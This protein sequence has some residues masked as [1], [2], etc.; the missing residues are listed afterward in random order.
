MRILKIV[1]TAD[2]HLGSCFTSTPEI[3]AQRKAEQLDT[4]RSIVEMCRENSSDALLIAG[5]LFDS[6]RVEPQLVAEVQDIL[7]SCDAKVFISPGNHDP[8]APDSCYMDEGWPE[9]VHIFKGGLERVDLEGK[10]TSIWGLGF[11]HSIEVDSLLTD[12]KPDD[13]YINILLMH[14]ELVPDEASE[15]RYN[16]VTKEKLLSLGMDYC[17]LGHIHKAQAEKVGEFMYCNCGCPEGRGFDELGDKG[18]YSGHVGKGFVHMEFVST[19]NRKYVSERV[20]VSG[21]SVVS[22]FCDKIIGAISKSQGDDYRNN[23]YSLTLIGALPK[24]IMPDITAISKKLMETVH[25]VRLTDMT[26]TELDINALMKDNSLR[27]A[28]VRNIVSKIERDERGR[29]KYLRAL[30]YGLRAFDGEVKIHEDN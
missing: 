2:L 16:P 13:N 15:S 9:N 11:R 22:E 27:G 8:A 1:H 28:F 20:D 19:C 12:F 23:I 7:G 3:A 10:K 14:A 26:T 5:D 29:D 17:A 4:L 25:Y 30:L 6:M 24:G 18:V 21:C